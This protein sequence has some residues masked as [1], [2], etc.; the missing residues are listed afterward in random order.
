MLGRKAERELLP[1]QKGDVPDTYADV[2]EL[3]AAVN[4]KPATPVATASPA[5]FNGIA[6]ITAYDV[7]GTNF[8]KPS[9]AGLRR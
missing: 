9:R 8:A 1:L 2:S 3:A 5:S 6:T 4:Y 7:L